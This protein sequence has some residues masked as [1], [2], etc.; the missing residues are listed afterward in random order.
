M[1]P[2][3][4]KSLKTHS[5]WKRCGVGT[6]ERSRAIL[7]KDLKHTITCP[8]LC[9]LHCSFAF[10]IQRTFVALQFAHP[11]TQKSL[12]SVEVWLKYWKVFE[13]RYMFGGRGSYLNTCLPFKSHMFLLWKLGDGGN[14]WLLHLQCL[15]KFEPY[16]LFNKWI[17]KSLW[18]S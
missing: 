4:F 3:G 11:M 15:G 12:N 18:T 13:N 16:S 14:K 8:L 10:D 17:L 7:S 9:F 6:K 5:K 1:H 2:L